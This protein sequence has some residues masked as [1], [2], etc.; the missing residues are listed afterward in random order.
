MNFSKN[1]EEKRGA[2]ETVTVYWKDNMS[3]ADIASELADTSY[4]FGYEGIWYCI[5]PVL[6]CAGDLLRYSCLYSSVEQNRSYGDHARCHV[7]YF[8]YCGLDNIRSRG[9]KG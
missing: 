3:S 8:I 6:S 9:V 5:V 4:E 7:Y 1:G 2:Y